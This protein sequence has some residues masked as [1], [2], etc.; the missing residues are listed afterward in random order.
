MHMYICIKSFTMQNV[1]QLY[2][3]SNVNHLHQ[4]SSVNVKRQLQTS[5]TTGERIVLNITSTRNNKE[6][7]TYS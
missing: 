2:L 6:K 3:T 1:L 4:T 5:Y 7:E